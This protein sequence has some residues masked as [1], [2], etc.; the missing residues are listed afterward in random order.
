M[1]ANDLKLREKALREFQ[2]EIN[3]LLKKW[4]F[5]SVMSLDDWKQLESYCV[6]QKIKRY[7]KGKA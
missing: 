2:R 1:K 4:D 5:I 7:K 3:R 6:E